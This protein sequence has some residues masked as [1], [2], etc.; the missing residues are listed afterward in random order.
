MLSGKK[1]S[2]DTLLMTNSCKKSHFL[3]V[4]E[5]TYMKN[6]MKIILISILICWFIDGIMFYFNS[7]LE[8]K[9]CAYDNSLL[10]YESLEIEN[11]NKNEITEEINKLF[12]NPFYFKINANL[13]NDNTGLIIYFFR[14]IIIDNSLPT[15]YYIFCLAHELSHLTRS[16]KNETSAN[17]NA[18]K[19]LYESGNP[20]FV[21]VAKWYAY[22]NMC[23]YNINEYSFWYYV[24]EYLKLKNEIVGDL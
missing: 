20:D 24:S 16:T 6:T 21:S 18:F 12:G 22:K 1:C 7:F 23:N 13:T 17:F 9:Y 3:C 10:Q 4:K 5:K 14:I 2:I 8:P 19:I 15:E 11:H